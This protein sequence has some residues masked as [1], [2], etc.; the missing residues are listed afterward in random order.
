MKDNERKVISFFRPPVSNTTPEKN[1]HSLVDIYNYIRTDGTTKRNTEEIRKIIAGGG[2]PRDAKNSLLSHATFE[3]VFD[4]RS[5]NKADLDEMGRR[6]L[7][8]PSGYIIV[9]IDHVPEL[10]QDL[11]E[12]RDK[13]IH[14]EDLGLRLLFISPSGDGLKLICKTLWEI[15][16]E[17]SYSS[18]YCCLIGYLHEKYNLP[19]KNR[20]AKTEGLDLDL[21]IDR[22]CY[23]CHDEDAFLNDNETFFN[24]DSHLHTEEEIKTEIE[25]MTQDEKKVQAPRF[26][27]VQTSDSYDMDY[28]T[29]LDNFRHDVL[30]PAMFA[31]I[32]TLFPSMGFEWRDKGD[33]SGWYSP[34]KMDGSKPRNPRRERD[35]TIILRSTPFGVLENGEDSGGNGK[36]VG[37]IDCYMQ[38]NGLDFREALHS[39]CSTLGLTLPTPPQNENNRYNYRFKPMDEE[40]I[41]QDAKGAQN[42]EK[43][44]KTDNMERYLRTMNLTTMKEL[45]RSRKPGIKTPFKFDKGG[46]RSENLCLRPGTIAMIGAKSTHGKSKVLQNLALYLSGLC[47]EGESILYFVYEEPL[48]DILEQFSNIEI[49]KQLSNYKTSNIEQIDHYLKT[50][51]TAKIPQGARQEF[52]LGLN[53]FNGYINEGKL[54]VICPDNDKVEELIKIVTY[55]SDKTRIRAVFVDYIQLLYTNETRKISRPEELKEVSKRLAKL[56]DKLGVPFVVA[57]QLNRMTENPETMSEDN[58]ADSADLTRYANT[59]LNLWNSRFPARDYKGEHQTK[60][61][62]WGFNIGTPGKLYFRLEKNRGGTAKID[63]VFDFH[64]ETGKIV[65]NDYDENETQDQ[66]LSFDQSENNTRLTE[67]TEDMFMRKQ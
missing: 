24:A 41:N 30:I 18:Q 37:V 52:T 19:Y 22:T 64:E 34:Y 51:E 59:I 29:K 53:R 3:G 44:P 38:H 9:D 14:D 28:K 1:S 47:K 50:G 60:L 27:R 56:A 46:N 65:G 25:S 57:A 36:G 21:K 11:H 17:T 20:K 12:L 63:G 13:L 31:N 66:E 26:E 4:Y 39:L 2:S 45:A 33:K 58:V 15:T 43:E 49:D 61:A 16:D 10:G 62:G 48:L 42:E 5:T 7:I 32:P 54:R 35:K 67:I 8:T 6:G 40:T 55:L 23:L